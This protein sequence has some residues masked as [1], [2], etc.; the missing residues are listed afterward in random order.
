MA[1]RSSY[2][3]S[4]NRARLRESV[5]LFPPA[6]AGHNSQERRWEVCPGIFFFTSGC[7]ASDTLCNR[8]GEKGLMWFRIQVLCI[9]VFSLLAAPGRAQQNNSND[10]SNADVWSQIKKLDWQ[11]GPT[12][13]SIAGTATIVVPKDSVFLGSTG[14]RRF[15]E[16]QGPGQR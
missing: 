2:C 7:T 14:T 9:V 3:R 10:N 16:L 13:G 11:F 8:T 15:L 4:I 12:Q 6:P 5:E 1:V